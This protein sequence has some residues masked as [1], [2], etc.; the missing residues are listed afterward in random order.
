MCEIQRP[1]EEAHEGSSS[2]AKPAPSRNAARGLR[3]DASPGHLGSDLGKDESPGLG[4][5]L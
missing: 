2:P 5:A 1:K 4:I 3:R